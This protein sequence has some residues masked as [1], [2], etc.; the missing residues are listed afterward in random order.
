MGKLRPV[1]FFEAAFWLLLS[2]FLYIESFDFDR[3]IEIYKFG[4]TAWP[5]TLILLMAPR[6]TWSAFISILC[7]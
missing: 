1:H 5:R 3:S 2:S 7:R 6:R 4:A